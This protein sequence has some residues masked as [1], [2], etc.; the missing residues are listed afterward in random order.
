MDENSPDFLSER[1]DGLTRWGLAQLIE[2]LGVITK[3]EVTR[4]SPHTLQN[5]FSVMFLCAGGSVFTPKEMLGH[6]DLP[7]TNRYVCLAQADTQN[8]LQMYSPIEGL[9]RRGM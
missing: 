6:A 9:K 1:G 4:C 2:R 7:M 3:K 8:Q 5:T